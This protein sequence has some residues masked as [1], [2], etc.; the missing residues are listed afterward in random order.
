MKFINKHATIF[1][2]TPQ[3][4]LGIHYICVPTHYHLMSDHSNN[5]LGHYHGP[6]SNTASTPLRHLNLNPASS[7][8]DHLLAPGDLVTTQVAV[9]GGVSGV[10]RPVS[11]SCPSCPPPRR[12]ATPPPPRR[13]VS[14]RSA[15]LGHCSV[16]L[17][18]ATGA[19]LPV[20]S[21]GLPSRDVTD[22]RYC[23]CRVCTVPLHLSA[24]RGTGGTLTSAPWPAVVA[25]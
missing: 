1:P 14:P 22:P 16:S 15:S 23:S 21:P 4:Q 25:F 10:R 3:P 6:T 13:S 8:G 19:P 9:S 5:I 12:P 7:G 17:L 20:S 11:P 2:F 18:D 24:A